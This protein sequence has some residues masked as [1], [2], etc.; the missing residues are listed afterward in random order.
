MMISAV[1]NGDPIGKG[2]FE[3]LFNKLYVF[4]SSGRGRNCGRH[5]TGQS[6]RQAQMSAFKQIAANQVHTIL[7]QFKRGAGRFKNL[8]QQSKGS[9]SNYETKQRR[10]IRQNWPCLL[11]VLRAEE[12]GSEKCFFDPRWT[13]CGKKN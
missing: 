5:H 9:I 3:Q 1:R 6:N 8:W 11:S 2:L 13:I 10:P 4:K 7:V 12:K